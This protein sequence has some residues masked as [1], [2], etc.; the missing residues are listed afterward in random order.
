MSAGVVRILLLA[1]CLTALAGCETTSLK[2][3]GIFSKNPAEIDPNT[4]DPVATGSISAKEKE[5]SAAAFPLAGP[6]APLNSLV[7]AD[8]KGDVEVGK[9]QYR[10]GNYGDAEKHFR[11]AV[12]TSP[13]DIE[14]WVGLA[15]SYDRLKRFDLAD[16]A[17]EQ[18]IKLAGPRPEILNNQGYSYILRGDL[19]RA[20]AKLMA[21]VARDPANPYIQNNIALLEE[22]EQTGKLPAQ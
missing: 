2:L 8:P 14:A 11:R 17:Y 3:P 21:A 4:G 16:R 18:A 19:K 6:A 12:E 7:G 10:A 22:T 15:A 20:R 9:K 1:A 13:R 5:V